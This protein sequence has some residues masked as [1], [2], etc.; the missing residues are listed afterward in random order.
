MRRHNRRRG[1]TLAELLVAAV[2]LGA[3]ASGLIGSTVY[4]AKRAEISRKRAVVLAVMK[5]ELEAAR[6]AAKTSNL[7]PSTRTVTYTK[8]GKLA[9]ASGNA[10]PTDGLPMSTISIADKVTVTRK[11]TAISGMPKLFQVEVTGAWEGDS[12]YASMGSKT[13][14]LTAQVRVGE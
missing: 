6:A 11:V 2:F 7:S 14:T 10:L 3:A 4:T 9:N 13:L 1:T 5:N 12:S 8:G